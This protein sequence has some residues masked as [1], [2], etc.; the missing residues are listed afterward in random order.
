[1]E[2]LPT[3]S[4]LVRIRQAPLSDDG[5]RV[6]NLADVPNKKDWEKVGVWV[7]PPL[8]ATGAYNTSLCPIRDSEKEL[9]VLRQGRDDRPIRETAQLLLGALNINRELVKL[10][11]LYLI[12]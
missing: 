1:M 4:I 3:A 10:F 8:Y 12:Y 6:L 2:R 5:L 7:P 11:E 9:F